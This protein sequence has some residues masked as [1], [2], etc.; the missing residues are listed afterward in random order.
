[1]QRTSL[2]IL[3]SAILIA[4]LFTSFAH[5]GNATREL[6]RMKG[7]TIV[8]AAS[9]DGATEKGLDTFI[10]LDNQTAYVA[11][12]VFVPPLP[13]SDVIV[14]AKKVGADISYKL[15]I[16]NDIYDATPA[17]GN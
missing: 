5:A 7:Y 14:F 15:M 1:M 8:D 9:V 13:L 6:R 12:S 17:G 11:R 4:L 3:S 2:R 16:G 10:E